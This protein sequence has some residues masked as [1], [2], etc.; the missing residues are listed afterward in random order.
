MCEAKTNS[1][2]EKQIAQKERRDE[3]TWVATTFTFV[4]K[5]LE[6]YAERG[7]INLRAIQVSMKQKIVMEDVYI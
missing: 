3:R 2:K 1:N 4:L 7:D 6:C 5:I